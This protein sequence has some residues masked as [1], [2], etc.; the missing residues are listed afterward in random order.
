MKK[1]SPG[2]IVACILS[3]I[4]II[5]S[6][7]V[8]FTNT[9][10][11]NSNLTVDQ[12]KIINN[13]YTDNSTTTPATVTMLN[14]NQTDFVSNQLLSSLI[15]LK[16]NGNYTPETTQYVINNLTDQINVAPT[17]QFTTADITIIPIPTL[18]DTKNYANKFWSIRAKYQNLY[19]QNANL[20]KNSI[21]DSSSP[22]YI[23]VMIY[24]GNLYV[25]MADEL[26]NLSVPKELADLHLKLLNNYEMEGSSLKQL[27][28]IDIDPV[29]AI[30]GLNTY[31]KYSDYEDTMLQILANYFSASGI[32]FSKADPGIG[33]KSL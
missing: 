21:T 24:A 1:F 19:T 5:L 9:E 4:L 30:T 10:T 25:Q 23:Q 15:S 3:F 26:K 2:I 13:T 14:I 33:W 28:N 6:L 12:N 7:F 17:I 22:A 16:E 18:N 27:N 29:L 11:R 8:R 31:S 32:I 20:N